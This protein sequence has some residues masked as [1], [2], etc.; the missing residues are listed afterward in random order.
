MYLEIHIHAGNDAR[1][2]DLRFM[3]FDVYRYR[4]YR[5]PVH[6]AGWTGIQ[7]IRFGRGGKSKL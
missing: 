5:Y 2:I 6:H 1:L 4:P 7:K 3:Y